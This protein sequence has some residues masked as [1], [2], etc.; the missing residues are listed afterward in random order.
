VQFDTRF[1]NKEHAVE[2][3]SCVKEDDGQWRPT[4]YDIR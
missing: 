2:T 4:G 1:A 3:V